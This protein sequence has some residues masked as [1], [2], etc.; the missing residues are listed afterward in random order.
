MSAHYGILTWEIPWREETG[1]LQS[2]CSERVGQDLE[3]K[4][5]QY[6]TKYVCKTAV[7]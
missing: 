3:T 7:S 6:L 5:Q 2:M 4:Q 1:E